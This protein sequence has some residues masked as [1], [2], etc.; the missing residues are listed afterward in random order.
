MDADPDFPAV[1][2]APQRPGTH[3]G[4][5]QRGGRV[6]RI[7]LPL[8]IGVALLVVGVSSGSGVSSALK[9]IGRMDRNWLLAAAG[10]EMLAYVGLS[11][12][13]R[14]LAGHRRNARWAAPL[15]TALI[16]FGLGN[17]LPAAPAEGL[18]LAGSALRRR[19]L[20]PRRITM[21]LGGSQW[22]VNRALFTI[23]ALDVLVA[24]SLGDIPRPYLGG[25][26]GA[27]LTT[28]VLL[29]LTAWLSLRRGTA[30]VMAWLLLRLRYR[31]DGPSRAAC[32]QRGAAWHR[33]VLYVTGSRRQRA[34]LVAT[35][36]VS[37]VCDGLCMYLALRAAGVHLQLDQ[38]MLAYTA[39][40]IASKA[41]LVPGGLGVVETVTPLFL[42]HYGVPWTTAI[43]VVLVYRLFSTVLPAVAG[44]LAYLDL[45]VRGRTLLRPAPSVAPG[46]RVPEPWQ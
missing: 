5:P 20:D 36:G 9:T 32:R 22:Y 25:A 24:V 16:V 15:R 29:S 39:G 10:A 4:R 41:P 38:L 14:L 37:W 31:H 19:P 18:L 7:L 34:R 2:T 6:A 43:A 8:G 13:L 23:A 17:V 30:E 35:G 45:R 3:E 40:V 28:L 12:H 27:A 1:P 42:V 44:L 21:L 26:I 33:V 46:S 11:L